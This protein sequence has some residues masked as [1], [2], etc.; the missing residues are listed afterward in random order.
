MY[1][2]PENVSGGCKCRLI[3]VKRNLK[4]EANVVAS[5]CTVCYMQSLIKLYVITWYI[6]FEGCFNIQNTPLITALATAV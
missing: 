4:V 3:S 6:L 2:K 5:E 1:L